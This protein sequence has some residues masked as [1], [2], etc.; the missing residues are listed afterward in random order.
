MIIDLP[1]PKLSTKAVCAD[2]VAEERHGWLLKF[3]S[4]LV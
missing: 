3:G 2:S 1:I 4:H